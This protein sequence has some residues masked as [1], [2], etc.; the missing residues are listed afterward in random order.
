M[1]LRYFQVSLG[2]KMDPFKEERS[3]EEVLEFLVDLEKWKTFDF[4]YSYST[5]SLN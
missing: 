1:N 5:I 3:K 4:P 2:H